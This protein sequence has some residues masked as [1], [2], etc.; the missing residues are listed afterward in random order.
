MFV[1]FADWFCDCLRRGETTTRF[2]MTREQ[3][4]SLSPARMTQP[5][6]VRSSFLALCLGNADAR[7]G[8]KAL[9]SLHLPTGLS[10]CL[11]VSAATTKP[12]CFWTTERCHYWFSRYLWFY[13]IFTLNSDTFYLQ[14]L[15]YDS[16]RQVKMCAMNIKFW[17]LLQ[18]TV[19]KTLK[20]LLQIR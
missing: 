16:D 2:S 10:C 5:G 9:P 6:V 14:F 4:V 7:N 18:T 11:W 15:R 13:C 8:S 12:G 19:V 17:E 3:S 1:F 20:T